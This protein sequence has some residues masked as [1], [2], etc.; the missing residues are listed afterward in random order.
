MLFHTLEMQARSEIK[1]HVRKKKM[2]LIW[3]QKHL[4]EKM[5][6]FDIL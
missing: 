6:F 4:F 5:I 3:M 2:F 1:A